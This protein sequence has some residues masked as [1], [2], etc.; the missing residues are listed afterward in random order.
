[1]PELI[2]YARAIIA[3]MSN[4][5]N[6]QTPSPPLLEVG[7]SIDDLEAAEKIAQLRTKGAA[8][9]RNEKRTTALAKLDLLKGYVQSVA[10]ASPASAA[11]IIASASMQVRKVATRPKRAFEVRPGPVSGSVKI[12]VPSAARR[13]S[14]DWQYS[15]D[16][17]STWTQL[18]TTLQAQ[19]SVSALQPGS[20]YEF[21]YR[22][23]TKTGAGDWSAPLSFKMQ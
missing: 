2:T 17:G 19:T 23:V 14:Y 3:A 20:T 9:A 13:V 16:G 7:K 11:D 10:D 15:A 12:L 22:A 6:F 1:V 4:N 18:P 21:R 5:K 8:L